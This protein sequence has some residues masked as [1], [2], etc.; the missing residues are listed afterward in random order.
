MGQVAAIV[1]YHV[2]AF[3]FRFSNEPECRRRSPPPA[4]TPSS[5]LRTVQLPLPLLA[6][7]SLSLRSRSSCL[8]QPPSI[9]L[10]S[11]VRKIDYVVGSIPTAIALKKIPNNGEA[12]RQIPLRAT[13]LALDVSAKTNAPESCP[14]AFLMDAFELER[15]LLD[16]GR[17]L[18]LAGHALNERQAI[19]FAV[20]SNVVP[21]WRDGK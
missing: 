15:C 8:Y 18:S 17:T 14:G 9:K 19:W 16:E 21:A 6:P 10:K 20:T 11:N 13:C 7:S 4:T 5:Y 3:I 1:F 12:S 2:E